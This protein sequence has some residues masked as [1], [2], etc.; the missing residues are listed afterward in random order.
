MLINNWSEAFKETKFAT[1]LRTLRFCVKVQK[2][3]AEILPR[4][5]EKSDE[6]FIKVF[7]LKIAFTFAW[8]QIVSQEKI[9]YFSFCRSTSRDRKTLRNMQ[10]IYGKCFNKIRLPV[11]NFHKLYYEL[12]LISRIERAFFTPNQ[13]VLIL[14]FLVREIFFSVVRFAHR[15]FKKSL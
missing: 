14:A 7:S 8:D 15:R 4:D 12:W 11:K 9:L 13:L 10:Q 5:R 3:T 6:N 1:Q 2:R